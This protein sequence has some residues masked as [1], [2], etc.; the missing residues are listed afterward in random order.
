MK[1][2]GGIVSQIRDKVSDFIDEVF[3]SRDDID[4]DEALSEIEDQIATWAE[5]YAEVVAITEITETIEETVMD[6]LETQ[7]VTQIYWATDEKPCAECEANAEASPIPLGSTWP[8]GHKNP[9]GHCRCRCT[10]A[11]G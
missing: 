2:V 7:G 3:G 10:T 9:P 5:D 8:S 4:P 11:R 6:E 1:I